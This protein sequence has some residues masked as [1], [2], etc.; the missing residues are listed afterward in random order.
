MNKVGVIG[1]GMRA[2][3]GQEIEDAKL[4]ACTDYSFVTERGERWQAMKESKQTKAMKKKN[5][6]RQHP[7]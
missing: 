6:L 4:T 1:K 7:A 2:E 3:R 5:Y